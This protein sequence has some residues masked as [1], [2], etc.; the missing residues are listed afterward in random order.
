MDNSRELVDDITCT[1]EKKNGKEKNTYKKKTIKE[2]VFGRNLVKLMTSK[3]THD[4]KQK[5]KS[6]K[7][8][9]IN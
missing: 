4:S 3:T 7:I 9:I 8:L 6:L 2:Q 5:I 1:V